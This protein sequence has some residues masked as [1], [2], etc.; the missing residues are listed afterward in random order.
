MAARWGVA[1]VVMLALLG[2]GAGRWVGGAP[3]AQTDG[4]SSSG[5]GDG[6]SGSSGD[7]GT[8]AGT[9]T[10]TGG[11]GDAPSSLGGGDGTS[12]G[13]SSGGSSGSSG[14]DTGDQGTATTIRTP[15]PPTTRPTATTPT[16]VR[17]IPQPTTTAPI[18]AAQVSPGQPIRC[19]ANAPA[20]TLCFKANNAGR[21]RA[22]RVPD[23][24]GGEVVLAVPPAEAVFDSGDSVSVSNN[25]DVEVNVDQSTGD[26]INIER[27][28]DEG[29]QA[30]LGT[31]AALLLL[32]TAVG[33]G[34]LGARRYWSGR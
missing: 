6:S 16:T 32:L 29:T 17:R 24:A 26:I 18:P 34:A 3:L 4:G 13:G 33:A 30:A 15:R 31:L 21:A 23:G 28:P 12:N 20:G 19:P 10:G 11:A 8:G 5:S 7:S 22:V 14:R 9:G 27:R 2:A 1:V 25:V